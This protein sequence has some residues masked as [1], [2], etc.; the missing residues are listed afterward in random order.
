MTLVVVSSSVDVIAAFMAEH[1]SRSAV[2]DFGTRFVLSKRTFGFVA[3]DVADGPDLGALLMTI[4]GGVATLDG[5]VADPPARDEAAVALLRRFEET[6]SYQNCHKLVARVK[7][8]GWIAGAL[9][10]ARFRIATVV[11]RH[12]F[13]FDFVDFA[14][15]LA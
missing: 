10:R 4:E 14:K 5:L 12:Y 6:A 8:D 9:T 3:R 11:E 7:R 1:A 13:Q 15:W 2:E